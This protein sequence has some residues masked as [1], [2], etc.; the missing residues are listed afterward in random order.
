MDVQKIDKNMNIE[1]GNKVELKWLSP[2]EKPFQLGGFPWFAKEHI[3]RR[4]PKSPKYPIPEEV[5]LLANC[6]A[7]GQIRFRTDSEKLFIRVK[8]SGI[9]N[10]V[11]MPATGQCGFDFYVGIADKVF[12]C[13]TTRYDHTKAEYEIKLFEM[14]SKAWKNVVINFPLYKGVEEVLIGVEETAGLEE[15]HSYTS[16]K[17]IIFYGTSVTQGGCASR[18]GMAY[19]N[20]ISRRLNMEIFNLGFS[21]NGK[22]EPE[23]AQILTEIDKP[24]CLVLDYEGNCVSTELLSKTLTQFIE[25][26]RKAHANVP[27]LVVSRA[28]YAM[29]RFN[30]E[31]HRQRLERKLLQKNTVESFREMGDSHIYFYD[32]ENLLGNDYEECTVDGVHPTDLGFLR[33]ADNLE[34][35]L[36]GIL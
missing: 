22:G 13:N 8:L 28:P 29:E 35:A 14:K 33:M 27:I 17:R 16:D 18:P 11:H 30:G 19:T 24:A 36:L 26:Y 2:K 25:I 34:K 9:A 4:L 31:L 1:T 12:Y 21:G 20:I 3:Y 15:P 5:D 23:V 7:G 10:M 6:I 32:G